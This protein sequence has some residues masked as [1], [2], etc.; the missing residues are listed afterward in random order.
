VLVEVSDAVLIVVEL[1][2]EMVWL[3]EVD[4]VLVKVAVVVLAVLELVAVEV[5]DVLLAV[6]ED[7]LVVVEVSDIVVNVEVVL[8][9]KV[10]WVVDDVAEVVELA[11]AEEV[12]VVELVHVTVERVW[13]KV[14][15]TD[16]LVSVDVNVGVV[17]K[18]VAV[19]VA[20]ELVRDEVAEMLESVAVAEL[21]L[22]SVSEVAVKVLEAML[23]AEDMLVLMVVNVLMVAV[24]LEPAVTV[25]VEV[26]VAHRGIQACS[27]SQPMRG[28][29]S[30]SS[31]GI[32]ICSPEPI[33]SSVTSIGTTMR[34][35]VPTG[36]FVVVICAVYASAAQHPSMP[37]SLPSFGIVAKGKPNFVPW[38][39]AK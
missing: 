6:V 4:T 11:D 37:P 32:S 34:P 20:V 35:F 29:H 38:Q 22:V 2:S 30:L 21:E 31:S 17:L 14:L 24:V 39:S 27:S 13:L 19:L 12:L 3:I 15:V 33:S 7:D 10:E 9:V 5:F 25:K 1:V 8:L 26:E 16:V 18:V 36:Y 23:N 28:G